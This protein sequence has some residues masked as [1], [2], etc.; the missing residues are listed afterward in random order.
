MPTQ[1]SIPTLSGLPLELIYEI[2]IRTDLANLRLLCRTNSQ[3]RGICQDPRFWQLKAQHDFGTPREIFDLLGLARPGEP[4]WRPTPKTRYLEILSETDCTHESVDL[5]NLDTALICAAGKG[6]FDL[7]AFFI[8]LFNRKY[9]MPRPVDLS[10]SS[11]R[12]E[13]CRLC[14][15]AG[16]S[17]SRA[18]EQASY[19]DNLDIIKWLISS[20]HGFSRLP[21][22]ELCYDPQITIAKAMRGAAKVNHPAI[23]GYL[24]SIGMNQFH[25]G[26]DYGLQGAAEGHHLELITFFQNLSNPYRWDSPAVIILNGA[27]RGGHLDLV[28]QYSTNLVP[29]QFMTPFIAAAEGGSIPILQYFIDHGIVDTSI[30]DDIVGRATLQASR[31]GQTDVLRFLYSRFPQYLSTLDLD[32]DLNAAAS[33]GRQ[34]SILYLLSCHPLASSIEKAWVNAASNNHL[35]VAELL[36]HALAG[37][38]ATRPI[39]NFAQMILEQSVENGSREGVQYALSL[40]APLTQE[41]YTL[42]QQAKSKRQ[43]PMFHYLN[44]IL[45]RERERDRE[46]D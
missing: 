43:Y 32:E 6:D 44:W 34:S 41:T 5:I 42:S 9:R 45:S 19:T 10:N 4:V 28:E 38:P 3:F 36:H 22:G 20:I 2:S 8:A 21:T 18:L 7:V 17:L 33:H 46:R 40:G 26:I 1:M 30:F 31:F 24:A 15:V 23:L 11:V 39:T 25:L 16:D 37:H 29:S 12:D 27:S 13:T 35:E 14:R